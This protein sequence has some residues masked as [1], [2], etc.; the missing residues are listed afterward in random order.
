M[1]DDSQ[2]EQLHPIRKET[3]T[4]NVHIWKDTNTSATQPLNTN[5][6]LTAW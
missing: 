3:L 4:K 1:T 5:Y 6:I 2:D